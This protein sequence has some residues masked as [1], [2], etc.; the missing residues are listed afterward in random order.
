MIEDIGLRIPLILEQI[1]EFLDNKTLA[2]CMEVSSTFCAII[3]NQTSGRFLTTRKMKSY[4][5]NSNEYEHDWMIVCQKLPRQKLEE[6]AILVKEFH[7]AAPM[8][9]EQRWSPMH[10]AAECGHLDLCKIIAKGIPWKNPQCENNLTPIHFAANAGHL[11]V[12]K[13]LTEDME[14]KNPRADRRLSPLHLAAKI[15]NLPIYQFIC[16]YALDKNPS[17]DKNVTPLHLAA[18]FGHFAVCKYICDNTR[19]EHPQ[20]SFDGATPF[21]LA[22]LRGHTRIAK[23]LIE[24]D[25]DDIWNQFYTWIHEWLQLMALLV[26]WLALLAFCHQKN[27]FMCNP[28]ENVLATWDIF[29]VLLSGEGKDILRCAPKKDIFLLYG[30]YEAILYIVPIGS[31]LY[32]LSIVTVHITILM[33][34][35]LLDN[36]FSNYLSPILDYSCL[37]YQPGV[38]AT[39]HSGENAALR[40][41]LISIVLIWYSKC[42]IL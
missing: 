2:N 29:Q 27:I 32:I 4:L 8:R 18:Q 33:I 15:G 11:D 31:F 36:L 7:D 13:F 37:F 41:L 6:F 10:I 16:E 22:I 5:K 42:L 28:K 40:L 30:L 12:Y 38:I 19:D 3:E 14:D 21:R 26:L 39:L 23:H 17:M 9:S 34:L 25:L 24:N 20:R 35:V 1:S